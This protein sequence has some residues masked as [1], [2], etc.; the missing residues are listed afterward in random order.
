[1]SRC[2]DRSGTDGF[3]LP[4]VLLLLALLSLLLTQGLLDAAGERAL[5]TQWQL[6][7]S[8]FNAAGNGLA[9]ALHQLPAPGSPLP[10]PFTLVSAE[11]QAQVLWLDRGYTAA[12]GYSADLYRAHQLQLQSTGTAARGAAL[13][14]NVGVQRVE[15]Q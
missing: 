14:L 12:E 3:A 1:M 9:Q 6:R 8:V 15:R 13:Q 4:P 2:S 5:S 11:A 10:A 7:Q